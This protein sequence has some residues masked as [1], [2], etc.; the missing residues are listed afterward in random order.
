MKTSPR[1][2]I[3]N[4]LTALTLLV[5]ILFPARVPAQV[6]TY[7]GTDS[8]TLDVFA[9]QYHHFLQQTDGEDSLETRLNF[10]EGLAAAAAYAQ[11]TRENELFQD[12][13]ILRAGH[14]A[15]RN[16]LLEGV[17]HGQFVDETEVSTEE[18]EAEY[19]Y[20]NTT[21]LTRFL[22]L[23]DSTTAVEFLRKLEADEPFQSLALQAAGTPSLLAEP[24]EPGWKYPH[25][26]D[27]TY[28][29]QA[30]RLATGQISKP[31]RTPRGF[32]II[33]LLGKE[34]R[35][36][37]G[38]FERVKHFQRIGAELHPTK[39]T[40][41]AR[42]AIEQWVSALPIDWRRRTVRKVLRAGILN[43]SVP[44]MQSNPAA[45]QLGD[46]VLFTLSDET[47]T[48][49]WIFSRLDLLL[50]EERLSVTNAETLNELVRLL[51]KWEHL[52]ALA[53]SSPLAES[54]VAAADSMRTFVISKAVQ[55]SI[56]TR[57]LRRATVPDDTLRQYLER[58][59]DR[60]TAPALVNLEEIVMRDST[61]AQALW[62]SIAQG[63]ADFGVLAA[64]HTERVWARDTGG[65]L[66]W[67][68]LSLYGSAA[69][70]LTAAAGGNP[71]RLVGPL[72]VDQH[73]VIAR[74]SG[75]QPELLPP[76]AFLRPRLKR[77]WIRTNRDDL[78]KAEIRNMLATTYPTTIDTSLL[79]GFH[80]DAVGNIVF[81][82]TSDSAASELTTTDQQSVEQPLTSPLPPD[83]TA[84]ALDPATP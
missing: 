64:R 39:I 20:Q 46:E 33:Q 30:Y 83:S 44:A 10:L 34:F 63:K 24:G 37:H 45:E 13:N 4:S 28:A 47:F 35:P 60:Y 43:H 23:P 55:D 79:A 40:P 72:Q 6:V 5:V 42:A 50:P 54:L 31:V 21:L 36:S 29:R 76:Y 84:G 19:R 41:T 59:Q 80:F 61:L 7:V 32:T 53:A 67:V 70:T 52:N 65:R 18:I 12:P 27:S 62:D 25:E 71:Q 26:L 75:Y 81:P 14:Q 78:I 73:Y 49:N 8:L 69:E 17:A 57:A 38:H 2:N 82:A 56:H 11:Y 77:E 9:E 3:R 58:H 51:L 68:P 48:L 66:G 1:H 22:L 15:W 74:L 16:T